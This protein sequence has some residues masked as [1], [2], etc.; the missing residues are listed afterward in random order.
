MWKRSKVTDQTAT[1]QVGIKKKSKVPGVMITQYVEDLPEG[2]STPDFTRKPIA[3]T[4]QEG[5]LAIFKAVVCGDPKPVVTWRRAKGEVTDEQKYCERYDETSGE[6]TLE[7]SKVSGEEADTYKCFAVNEFGKAICTATLNVIEVGFKRNKAN[8]DQVMAADPTEFRKMLRKSS[9]RNEKKEEKKEGEIDDKFWEILLSAE[10]KEYERICAE[11]GVTDFRWMLK[12]LNELKKEREEEQAMYLEAISNLRHIEVKGDGTASFELVLELK[13]PNSR[14]FLYKDGIMI[15]FSDN[16][17]KKHVLKTVGKKLI[18]SISNLLPEDAGL[19]QVDVEEV[20]VFSTDFKIPNIDFIV[21]IKEVK[22]KERE[23]AIFECVLTHPFSRI[24]WMGKNAPLEDGE[25]YKITVSEDKLIHKLRV[26]DCMQ[27]DKGIYTAIAG[28]KTCSAWLLVEAD[29]DA[30]APGKKAA[31]KTTEAGGAGVDLG[32]LAQ[33]Q[34]TKLQKE[35]EDTEAKRKTEVEPPTDK[36]ENGSGMASVLKNEPENGFEK[37]SGPRRDSSGDTAVSRGDSSGTVVAVDDRGSGLDTDRKAAAPV[38][39][40]GGDKSVGDG[41][42]IKSDSKPVVPDAIKGTDPNALNREAGE[43][44]LADHTGRGPLVTARVIGTD[45]NALN[46]EAGKGGLADH[47]GPGPLVADRVIGKP[48]NEVATTVSN[49]QE[50]SEGDDKPAKRGPRQGPLLVDKAIDPGV[51]CISGLS[52]VNVVMGESAELVCKLSSDECDGEWFKDGKKLTEGDGLTLAKDGACHKLIIDSCRED[53]SGKYRFEV[54]GRKTEAIIIVEDPPRFNPDDLSAFSKPVVVK[55]GQNATFKMPFVGREPVK[56]QWF[57]EGEELHD[58]TNVK[59]EKTPSHSRLLLGKCQRKDGGEVKIKLKNE[60]GTIEAV[61]RLVVLDKPSPP[62]GPVEVVENSASCIEIKWRPPKDDGGS[63]V[64]GYAVERQQVGRN[65]WKKLGEIVAG[66]AYRDTGVDHGRKYCYRIRAVSEE[67]ASDGMETEDIMAGTKAYPGPPAPPKVVGAFKDHIDL[68]WTTPTN[69]GGSR[70]LGYN[71][72]KRKMGSNL[73]SLVNPADEFIQGNKCEVKDVILGMAYEF[74]VSA[75]NISGTGE[76]S[77][78]SDFVTARDPKKPPGKV[79]DLKVTES[80]YTT[81]Y[82]AW[83]KPS[84]EEGVQDEAKGYF[85][86]IR[87]AE[88]QDWSRCN[89]NPLLMT[90]FTVKGLKSMGMYW[91]RVI[92][93]NDGGEGVPQDLDNYVITMP[94]PVRPRFTNNNMKSFMVVRAGNTVR[95]NVNFEASPWP[96]VIWQKDN[97]PVSKRV[98]ISNAEGMSQL[99]IPSSERCD[100]GVYT[101]IV[102]NLVGQ[103]TFSVEIRVTDVPKPP[104]PIELE[105]NVPGTVT[106]S[107]EP[108]P[109]EKRDDRLHYM[110]SKRDSSKQTWHTAAD[111]LFNNKFTACNI[112]PGREYHFRVYAKNDM[113]L[114][115]PAESPTWGTTRKRDKF[116]V[117]MPEHRARDLRSAPAFLV[118]LKT[119]IAPRGYECHMSCAVR[120]NPRPHVTWLRDS[121]SLNTNTNYYISNT[122]GVCS[123][124]ILRVN[125]NDHGEYTVMAENP[126]GRAECS[127]KLTVRE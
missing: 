20:N 45:P 14:I 1:G 64:K 67:G 4:I 26:V 66:P 49:K 106:V 123:M 62:Q 65:T 40:S 78:P 80:T 54:D 23:D 110:V 22:A 127:T 69:T 91:V 85:V 12:K 15:P 72:E 59:L 18:F 19:Y 52:N 99:L 112:V 51:Q 8:E 61:S 33:E 50:A 104:G 118:P 100:T 17:E 93:T 29:K 75:V 126:L 77:L 38:A 3:L 86:E 37:D 125:P 103:E 95:V 7:I 30:V 55:A 81:L 47:T 114:S 105:E 115:E 60:F 108:S 44:G 9:G 124:L 76:P 63:Q 10:K 122:C 82:L 116:I 79:T 98:T 97:M 89:S 117:R 113:G 92:A 6:Y 109:D 73:W 96:D 83:T 2:K 121:I 27:L 5:K 32:K 101:I 84:E 102:K 39:E 46:R 58:D 53:D 24:R 35:K 107:W 71:L 31:R 25:K 28:I 57:K 36:Q 21:K 11:Y 88:S 111:H 94:P 119:H 74:R 16:M 68:T 56:V 42:H 87:P 120:G 41:T 70:I 90:S 34:Q 43:G 13:D 48:S